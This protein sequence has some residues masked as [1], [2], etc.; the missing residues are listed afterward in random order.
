MR[1]YFPSQNPNPNSKMKA[2]NFLLLF[3]T[4]SSLFFLNAHDLKSLVCQDPDHM[5]P[6]CNKTLASYACTQAC[7]PNPTDTLK[8]IKCVG[9]FVNM[10]AINATMAAWNMSNGQCTGYC[11]SALGLLE[12]SADLWNKTTKF[13]LS[14]INVMASAAE[15]YIETCTDSYGKSSLPEALK[16]KLDLAKEFIHIVLV[17]SNMLH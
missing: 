8:T 12:D 7:G 4:L 17:I 2:T 14:G 3:T 6:N 16:D 10:L 9:H 5:A 13:D 11:H 15:S 1:L